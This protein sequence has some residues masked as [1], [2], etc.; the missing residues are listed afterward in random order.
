MPVSTTRHIINILL[1]ALSRSVWENLGAQSIQ[2]KFHFVRKANNVKIFAQESDFFLCYEGAGTENREEGEM[3]KKK[4][5]GGRNR[6][7]K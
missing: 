1:T 4:L 7:K 5:R 6:G 2:P 3:A